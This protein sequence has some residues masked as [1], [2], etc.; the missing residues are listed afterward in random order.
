[1]LCLLLFGLLFV[2]CIKEDYTKWTCTQSMLTAWPNGDTISYVPVVPYDFTFPMTH[3]QAEM[4][5]KEHSYKGA[6][7]GGLYYVE[8]K[9]QCSEVICPDIPTT[10]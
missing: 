7:E 3:S 1:M 5:L 2:G 6:R 10:K 9:A 8:S 4:F